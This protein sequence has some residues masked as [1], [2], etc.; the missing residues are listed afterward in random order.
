MPRSLLLLCLVSTADAPA[1]AQS[2]APASAPFGTISISVGATTLAAQSDNLDAWDASP[3]L[4]VR[5]LFPFY[6]GSVELG[7]N[8]AAFDARLETLP[9]FRA[10]YVFIGWGLIARPVARLAWRTGARLGVYDLQFEDESI[11]DYARSE[12]EVGSELVTELTVGI[13]NGWDVSAGAGGRV[14]FTEPRIRQLTIAAGIR[15]TFV[16]PEWLRDFLD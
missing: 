11:P 2:H 3:G 4:E 5:A 10:R 7:A 6:A 15:R 13:G 8:Q 16:S 1:A 12:N 9:G 14:V